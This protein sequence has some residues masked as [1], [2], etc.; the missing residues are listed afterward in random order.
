[1][2][3]WSSY[4][5]VLNAAGS[6]CGQL[7]L[8]WIC[9][10]EDVMRCVRVCV[11]VSGLFYIRSALKDRIFTIPLQLC[12]TPS[13]G[14][15]NVTLLNHDC[16]PA[17]LTHIILQLQY[18]IEGERCSSPWCSASECVFLCVA[19]SGDWC[20]SCK[21]WSIEPNSHLFEDKCKTAE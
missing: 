7:F 9:K 17:V 1:M 8:K 6:S 4:W 12:S 10:E 21:R 19:A 20:C 3:N 11:C 16:V 13:A 2:Q 5:V 14:L 18:R 15:N